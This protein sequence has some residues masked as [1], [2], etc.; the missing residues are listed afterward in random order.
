LKRCAVKKKQEKQLLAK[1]TPLKKIVTGANTLCPWKTIE[2][3]RKARQTNSNEHLSSLRAQLPQILT[4]L[5]QIPD[6]RNPKKIKHKLTVLML[7]G[8]LMF[9]FQFTSRRQVNREMSR[10][11]F[12]E[13]LMSFFPEL[14]SLPHADTLFRLLGRIDPN[15]LEKTHISVVNKLIRQKKFKQYL[16]NNCY[17]VAIDGTQKLARYDLFAEQLLQ[18][19]ITK[20]KT[21]KNEVTVD[22]SEADQDEY[23]YYVYVLE[24]NL[25]FRHGLV[26]PLLS[27]F[28]EYQLGDQQKSK[29]DCELRAFY[30]LCN[31]LKQYFSHLPIMLLLDG[32]YANGPVMAYCEQKN[33]QFM[34][35]LKEDS[36]STVWQEFNALSKLQPANI[37][38]QSWGR[39]EQSFRWV[40]KIEYTFGQGN[41]S[42]WLHLVVCEERWV[43]VNNQGEIQ[44]KTSRHAWL[45]SRTVHAGNVHERCNLG[46]RYRWGIEACILVEK[47][48]GY[49]YEHCFTLNWAAMKSAHYL[50]RLAHLFNALA[51][52]SVALAETV[53][54]LGKRGTLEL[55]CSTLS[56]PWFAKGEI[57]ALINKPY[58]LRLQ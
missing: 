57:E 22:N 51:L 1:F 27:E 46:A 24:A 37:M 31:R 53:R 13:N 21:D 32:L 36:L 9:V 55:I 52:F 50:M 6:P 45:S 5:K 54:L 42:L 17:P 41:E 38:E 23:Q 14:A 35:V 44:E 47:H 25:S 34:I 28:L 15:T 2:Q 48:Q 20:K 3:A 11:Q 49:S 58:R 56:A 12:K 16:I 39:R 4:T 40:D 26:I 18:R 29:Q 8:L 10:P 33:W 43:E 30:R 7:Y 19:K